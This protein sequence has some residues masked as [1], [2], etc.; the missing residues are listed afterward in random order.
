MRLCDENSSAFRAPMSD[1]EWSSLDPPPHPSC[2]PVWRYEFEFEDQKSTEIFDSESGQVIEEADYSIVGRVDVDVLKLRGAERA[3]DRF[4]QTQ[5]RLPELRIRIPKSSE[6]SFERTGVN[7]TVMSG[8][9]L[10]EE[11]GTVPVETIPDDRY[12]SDTWTIGATEAFVRLD[13]TTGT[14]LEWKIPF[15]HAMCQVR[16]FPTRSRGSRM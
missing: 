10:G 13:L 9:R 8:P 12:V 11:F 16:V 5:G 2:G 6:W 4:E 14:S 15:A 3:I 1:G 7:D